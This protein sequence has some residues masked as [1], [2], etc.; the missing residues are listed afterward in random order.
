MPKGRGFTAIFGKAMIE[1]I[2]K[3]VI[4]QHVDKLAID[5]GCLTTELVGL[6]Q[7]ETNPLPN[8]EETQIRIATIQDGRWRRL[9]DHH[10]PKYKLRTEN[11]TQDVLANVL[12]ELTAALQDEIARVK[13]KSDA[14]NATKKE[15]EWQQSLKPRLRSYPKLSAY[16]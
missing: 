15:N 6:L 12:A 9:V 13:L 14:V 1:D 5:A 10:C 3:V 4:F 2:I 8:N 16:Q 7:I 11:G